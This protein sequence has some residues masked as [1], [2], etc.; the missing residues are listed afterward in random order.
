MVFKRMLN[1]FE[2]KIIA[3]SAIADLLGIAYFK[4]HIN[5]ACEAFSGEESIELMYFI[6]F[7][8]IDD[9]WTVFAKVN[10][11][12]E[13][14]EITFLDYKTPDGKRM[15]NPISPISFVK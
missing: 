11:N 14:K 2:S 1:K 8:G 10:V 9:Y 12:R 4:A 7:E 3:C 15:E 5:D 13:T 6:G